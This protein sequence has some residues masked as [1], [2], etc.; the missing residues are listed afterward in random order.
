M[1]T[2]LMF[3]L[4]FLFDLNR[5]RMAT[6]LLAKSPAKAEER[7]KIFAR[8]NSVNMILE[9]QFGI[10]PIKAAINGVKK[11]VLSKICLILSSPI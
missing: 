10:S 8:Y 7:G 3:S 5:I 2:I 1:L 9:P 11:F 4:V 6:P